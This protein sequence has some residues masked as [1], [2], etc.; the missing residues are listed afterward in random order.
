MAALAEK[1]NSFLATSSYLGDDLCVTKEDYRVCA[2][3]QAASVNGDAH[4]HL[5]RW[6]AH[7]T[8]LMKNFPSCDYRGNA[9]PAGK[10]RVG[11]GGAPAAASSPKTKAAASPKSKS[12]PAPAAAAGAVD[13]DAVKAVGDE[14]RAVKER[15]K[16]EG[17]TGKAMNDHAEVVALVAKLTQLKTGGVPKVKKDAPAAKKAEA[18]AK[19]EKADTPAAGDALS[20]AEARK[21]QLKATIKE[22]GKRGVEIEG[23]ADM[24]GLQFFCTSVDAPDGDLDLVVECVN[25]MNEKSD[26]TEEERKG[27]SGAIGKMVFSAGTDQ[28]AVVA[29]VQESKQGELDCAEWLAKVLSVFGGQVV[30]KD[31]SLSTGFVKA[32]GDKNIFPLKIREPMIL[33]ANNFLRKLGLFPEDNGDSDDEFVFGDDDFPS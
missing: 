27:G 14:L 28:L 22:G 8:Y 11:A 9:V 29:Y 1:L 32:D 5:A 6:H 13:E 31:K 30:K 10:D 33:E 17:V 19:K 20:E 18:P 26:P 15:L 25:A 21:K 2:S 24:G 4:P 3:M 12:A 23:A 7:V 16:G